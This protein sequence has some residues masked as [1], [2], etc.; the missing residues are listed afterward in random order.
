MLSRCCSALAAI[1]AAFALLNVSP[2][3]AQ[4]RVLGIDISAWQ[5]NLLPEDWTELKTVNSRDFAFIRSS[6]GGTTGF[7]NQS[8][9]SNTN[10]PGQ[11]TLS[12]R[13]DDPYFVQ[14]ITRATAAGLLA[15]P[16][17]FGRMDIVDD[18]PYAGG[19]AN[20]G[21]DEAEHFIQMA[22]AWM[23]PGY[24]L[25]TF[26]LEAGISQRSSADLTT[27]AIDF[28]N[29]IYDEFGIRPLVYIGGN[30][31]NYVQ[32]SIVDAFPNLW[33]ARWPNQSN[34]GSIPVQTANPNDS[35]SNLYGPW[36]NFGDPQPWSFW[37][38]ASTMK[39]S[40]YANGTA[41]I[42]VDVANGDIEFLK[43]NLVPAMWMTTNSGEWNDLAAQNWNSAITPV[44][45]VQGPGQVARVGP[46]TLPAVRLPSSNDTVILD[47]S[48][49]INVTLSAGA[50][51]IRK[52]YV[53]ENLSI[54]GGS[55]T[56]NYVPSTDS[57]PISAQFSAPVSLGGTGA[58]SVHTLQVDSLQ[59]FTVAGGSLTFKTINLMPR[60]SLPAVMSVTGDVAMAPL[61]ATTA[62]VQKGSGAGVSGY[63]DLNGFSRTFTIADGPAA[64]DVA[65]NVPIHNGGVTKAGPGVLV[66]SGANT[67]TGDTS[68]L[69]GKL[70]LTSPFLA[71][72]SDVYLSGDSILDL[73]FAGGPD[74]IDSLFF[75]GVEQLPGIY[76]G[77]GSGAQ[78]IS[79]FLSG[80][81]LLKVTHPT[82]G[83]FNFD[84]S[85]DS[86]DLTILNPNFGME[87]GATTSMGDANGDGAVDGADILVWQNYV[88][89][90]GQAATLAAA[91][92]EPHAAV[93]ALAAAGIIAARKRRA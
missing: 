83:D 7:Y 18:T 36:D 70:R 63:V 35:L 67:Y 27:F 9:A 73:A 23:R 56:V 34:P 29:K 2:A 37:Q 76:G 80:T 11:N 89:H 22:G 50:Q 59:T 68:V 92:P 66:L 24:L 3:S 25:P 14:N 1:V 16:Y 10:P 53:R 61:G 60:Q 31:A 45:P 33:I 85:V 15:G 65:I 4:Q 69:D 17:H 8:N 38:Y 21:T 12:Q 49:S 5:G 41:N 20:T 90:P 58:L 71:D 46:L 51:N 26:D 93:L 91:T 44:A 79:T 30:Y 47:T 40:G 13:Y 88:T 57:T 6:R 62:T 39:L 87:E 74:I 77:I 32:S 43:D 48:A 72:A 54:T 82:P 28:S 42:D 64:T 86:Q 19:I 75:D 84:L 78:Y 52:L 55:L 81:G